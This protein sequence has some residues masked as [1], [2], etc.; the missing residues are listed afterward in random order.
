M[1]ANNTTGMADE[2]IELMVPTPTQLPD[3]FAWSATVAT[4][5]AGSPPA[6]AVPLRSAGQF[7]VVY[8]RNDLSMN[9]SNENFGQQL[10]LETPI[11]LSNSEY[12]EET[13]QSVSVDSLSAI[14]LLYFTRLNSRQRA[15]RPLDHTSSTRRHSARHTGAMRR[16]AK[17][18]DSISHASLGIKGL[19][20]LY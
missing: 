5:M 4:K 16:K 7:P 15:W 19:L 2:Q 14:R 12:V 20:R 1:I 8:V 3:I 18:L 17:R 10:H 9:A 11:S 6:A 13:K